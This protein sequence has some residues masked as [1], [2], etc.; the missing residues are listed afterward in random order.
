MMQV[1]N[2]KDE[3]KIV[4]ILRLGFRPFFLVGP[5]FSIFAIVIWLLMYRGVLDLS[6]F[7]GGYWWHI[8][9]MIFGFGC[10]VVAGFLLTAVQSWTA[11]R[12]VNGV[13]LLLLVALWASG[14]VLLLMP[15]LLGEI[16]TSIVDLAFLPVLAIVLAKPIIAI[17]QYRNLFF[18]S[19]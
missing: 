15:S 2:L 6:V 3:Q 9:E 12:G 5:I 17:K 11:I 14:R 10:A 7:A 19:E 8:H 18:V 4:P 16:I 1:T 13:G